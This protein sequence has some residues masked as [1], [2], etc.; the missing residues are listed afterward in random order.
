MEDL[1]REIA[2]RH[3]VGVD[4]G[5]VAGAG[6]SEIKERGRA[7]SARADDEK[8]GGDDLFLTFLAEAGNQ[9]LAR[10]AL[11]KRVKAFVVSSGHKSRS[12]F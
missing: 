10:K 6:R 2:F 7:E 5:D 1:A 11:P 4:D 9:H 8:A 3:L 12:S